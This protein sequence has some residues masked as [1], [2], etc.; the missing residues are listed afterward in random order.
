MDTKQKRSLLDIIGNF[1]TPMVMLIIS[2]NILQIKNAEEYILNRL[3]IDPNDIYQIQP[4]G[5]KKKSI[6]IAQIRSI[7]HA[8]SLTPQ[9]KHKA[10]FINQ[11][12]LLTEEGANALLKTLE[13]PPKYCVF[14]LFSSHQDILS[15]IKSRSRIINLSGEDEEPPDHQ[16]YITAFLKSS[17]A[18]QSKTI[19]DIIKQEKVAEFLTSIENY[20]RGELLKTKDKKF[21]D[22]AEEVFL[23]KMC[24]RANVNTRLALE[25]LALKFREIV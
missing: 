7:I 13:E 3:D 9:K 21:S 2:S 10:V 25:N 1:E 22:L 12:N 20:S 17:F 8:V 15:T 16:K 24:L 23:T 6:S 5:E 11:A 19:E 14:T 18:K 4:E